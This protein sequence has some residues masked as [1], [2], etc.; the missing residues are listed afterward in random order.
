MCNCN[1]CHYSYYTVLFFFPSDLKMNGCFL[2]SSQNPSTQEPSKKKQ[3]VSPRKNQHIFFNDDCKAKSPSLKTKKDKAQERTGGVKPWKPKGPVPTSR[4]A[5]GKIIVDEA[6]DFPR[7]GS[8]GQNK[9]RFKKSKRSPEEQSRPTRP[10][11]LGETTAA[12]HP[13]KRKR[14]RGR[15]A[16]IA[17][18]KSDAHMYPADE[19]L[20]LIKQRRRNR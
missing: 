13:D 17:S 7:G 19:N 1:P 14:K 6:D 2:T 9:K 5:G 16:R 12:P 20:F 10:A 4:E 8:K 3:K 15:E 11:W 18:K